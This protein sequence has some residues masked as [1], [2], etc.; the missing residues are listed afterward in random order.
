MFEQRVLVMS[1]QQS[2]LQQ[3]PS[4]NQLDGKT[5][6]AYSSIPRHENYWLQSKQCPKRKKYTK[7]LALGI[8]SY[9]QVMI[10]GIQAIIGPRTQ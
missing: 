7:N 1:H 9:R 3:K 10:W 6:S 4:A 5:S 2:S 8:Q